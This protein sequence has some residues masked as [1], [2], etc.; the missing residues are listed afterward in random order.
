MKTIKQ[1]EV[2]FTC[3]NDFYHIII[4]YNQLLV[5]QNNISLIF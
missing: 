1:L 5:R 3:L 2:F 4:N